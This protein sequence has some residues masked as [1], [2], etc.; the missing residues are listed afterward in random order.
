MKSLQNETRAAFERRMEGVGL[1]VRERAAWQKWVMF[2]LD[3]CG[4]YGH[5]ARRDPSWGFDTAGPAEAW[6]TVGVAGDGPKANSPQAKAQPHPSTKR[7]EPRGLWY[8]PSW[9]PVSA[10]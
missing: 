2:Y 3:F 8:Q 6:R 9:A 5:S 7:P 1:P 4:K 10:R